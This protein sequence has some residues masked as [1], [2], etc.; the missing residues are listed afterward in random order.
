MSRDQ[1]ENQDPPKPTEGGTK[2]PYTKPLLVTYG[3]VERIT[4]A[5]QNVGPAKDQ[6]G[7]LVNPEN[8]SR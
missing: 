3:T 1:D 8:R 6:G 2:K 7:A 5:S 4:E